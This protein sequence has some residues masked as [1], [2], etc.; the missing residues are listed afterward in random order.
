M[1]LTADRWHDRRMD[2]PRAFV[3]GPGDGELIQSPLAGQMLLKARS[4]RT[5]GHFALLENEVAPGAGPALHRH[6]H[7]DEMYYVLEG[8]FRFKFVD[9]DGERIDRAD[10]GSLVVIPRGT[11][12]C[13]QHVGAEPGRF[14]VMFTPAGMERYFEGQARLAPGSMQSDEHRAIAAANGMEVL[15]PPLA[16]SDPL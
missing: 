2:D 5:G 6:E 11:A 1:D 9:A 12:H 4:E 13:F 8:S 16:I 3:S 15:G 14:L 10:A 7:E